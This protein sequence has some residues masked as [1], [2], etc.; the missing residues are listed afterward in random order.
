MS[1]RKAEESEVAINATQVRVGNVIL[2]EGVPCR[3]VKTHHHTPGNLRAQM[4]VKMVQLKDGISFEHRYRSSDQ[5]ELANLESHTLKYLYRDSDDYH[6]MSTESF[7]LIM[8]TKEVL[9]DN[10][11]YILEESEVDVKFFEGR[12]VSIELPIFV[13]LTV[14]DTEPGLKG[15]TVSSSPKAATLE[16]GLVTK[17]PQFINIGDKV[18]IDTRDGSFS[19]RA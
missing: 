1:T 4:H 15:A 11:Y 12:P 18:K 13:V 8:L 3:V 6:F 2:F 10:A 14:T 9:G 5:V 19:E 16:T 7:E 17:V